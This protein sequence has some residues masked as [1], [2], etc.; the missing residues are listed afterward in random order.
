MTDEERAEGGAETGAEPDPDP[1]PDRPTEPP[2]PEAPSP[3][4]EQTAVPDPGG[5]A[6][7]S[8]H[9]D[10]LRLE[11]TIHGVVV[12]GLVLLGLIV[13]TLLVFVV[14]ASPIVYLATLAP[15][16]LLV[17]PLLVLPRWAYRRYRYRVDD[18]GLEIRKGVWWRSHRFIPRSRLQHTDIAQGPLERRLDL[19][20]LVVHTAGTH[21][22]KT[23]VPGL[24]LE[25]ARRV[26]DRLI[27]ETETETA[28]DGV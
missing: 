7:Q 2:E 20:N 13:G 10:S 24:A 26:R 28:T 25:T 16:A 27:G 17:F 6:F 11:L 15:A 23:T 12:G 18:T 9:P 14:P 22:A 5:G 8:K 21:E 19:A 1:D 3:D 4:P